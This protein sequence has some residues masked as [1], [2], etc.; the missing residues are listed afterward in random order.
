[1][2]RKYPR[3][4][5]LPWSPGATSD[6]KTLRSTIHFEGLEVVVTE[7]MDGE[8]TT[9]Y[10]DA[11]HARSLDGRHHPSRDWV[12]A[13]HAGFAHEIPEGWR[14]CGENLYA[15]HSIAYDD[16]PGYFFLF[17]VWTESDQC[18]DW[19]ATVEWAGLLALP[20]PRVLYRGPWLEKRLRSLHEELD[21][22]RQEGY[23]VRLAEGFHFVD[24][25]RSVA[26][27]VRPGHVQSEEHWMHQAIHPNGIAPGNPGTG[28]ELP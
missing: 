2:L 22:S 24:F 10:R 13:L 11:M 3:T 25:P 1:M 28:R 8:N 5:H 14:L 26:K 21:L 9:L 23:V 20:L 7:K 27:W 6:D 15:R 17:S 18:L 4:H 19:D 12:K 16:L